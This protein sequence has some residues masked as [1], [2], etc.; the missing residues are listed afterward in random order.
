MHRLGFAGAPVGDEAQEP[1]IEPAIPDDGGLRVIPAGVNGAQ[2]RKV[3]KE[4]QRLEPAQPFPPFR[5]AICKLGMGPCVHGGVIAPVRAEPAAPPVRGVMHERVEL[6][7]SAEGQRGSV[8]HHVANE[9]ERLA[10]GGTAVDVVAE[11]DRATRRVPKVAALLAVSQTRQ[12]IAQDYR[13]AMNVANE[14]VG[15]LFHDLRLSR[16]VLGKQGRFRNDVDSMDKFHGLFAK[17]GLSLDRLRT[18]CL[19]AEA[20]SLTAAADRDPSRVSL[21]S[22]QLRELESFFGTRLA[23]RRGKQIALTVEGSELATMARRHFVELNDFARTCAG[24]PL[25]I[26]LGAGSSVTEWLLMPQLPLLRKALRSARLKLVR[27]RSEVLAMRLQD[28]Q[29]DVGIL[30]QDAVAAPLQTEPFIALRYALFLPTALAGPPR[31]L[32]RW[33]PKVPMMAPGEGWTRE[34]LDA[35][36]ATAGLH[37]RFEI[38]GASA[39]LAVRALR[40]GHCAAV[41]PEMARAELAGAKVVMMRPA[42]LSSIERWL[43]VAWHPRQAE[44]RPVTL[45]AVEAVRSLA[46]EFQ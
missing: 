43:V 45:R 33:L 15:F 42:F 27:E 1:I 29:L 26:T 8:F 2:A 37:L 3:Q 21:F 44:A 32:H 12:E 7:I 13:F 28:R 22:R 31:S 17:G 38:E 10:N 41:L 46:R 18:L 35:A 24:K 34:R 20:G 30:R 40:E 6:V 16:I 25:E 9:L 4:R 19:V 36:A 11:E 39:T 5:R 14:V 23:R